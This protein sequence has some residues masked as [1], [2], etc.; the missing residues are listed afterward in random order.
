MSVASVHTVARD[1][2]GRWE[3]RRQAPG[4]DLAGLVLEYMSYVEPTGPLLRQRQVG[5]T[6]IPV[7]INL[8]PAF[9]IRMGA[10]GV[11][12]TDC[13][14]FVAGFDSG[15]ADVEATGASACMQVDFSP[16]G[17]YR[18]FGLPM[19]D[20]A[21]AVTDLD[22]ALGRRF[23][24]LATRLAEAGAWDAR[25]DLLDW[26]VRD[27]LN[28][29]RPPSSEVA[30]AWRRLRASHGQV[31]IGALA[32]DLGW[33]RRRLAERFSIE[34]GRPAK[35]A[36]RLMRFERAHAAALAPVAPDWSG[37]ALDCGYADQAHMIREFRQFAGLSPQACRTAVAPM[38]DVGPI[39]EDGEAP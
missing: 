13:D 31:R 30:W 36:A 6:S 23:A 21:G 26:F 14:S 22:D 11:W 1:A 29:S 2:D 18:F 12:T 9:R 10:E 3:L 17:A 32:R 28:R 15:F 37:L 16:L 33:S 19:R 4:S 27:R 39:R 38:P 25:F 5:R 24:Q 7:I 20:L 35:T 8:G 34:V